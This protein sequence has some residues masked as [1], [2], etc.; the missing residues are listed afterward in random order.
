MHTADADYWQ[1][2]G[3]KRLDVICVAVLACDCLRQHCLPLATP[4]MT[5]YWLR[6]NF[7]CVNRTGSVMLGEAEVVVLENKAACFGACQN[8]R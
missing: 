1:I 7:Y 6:D 4:L 8:C 3:K 5:T 2:S